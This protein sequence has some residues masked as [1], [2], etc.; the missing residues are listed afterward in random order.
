MTLEIDEG[1]HDRA[2]SRV[3]S[4]LGR[5]SLT[6]NTDRNTKSAN[7]VEHKAAVYVP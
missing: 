6:V 5:V 4:T 1:E 3:S 7:C 2:V